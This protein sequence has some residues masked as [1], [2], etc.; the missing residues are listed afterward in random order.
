MR[1]NVLFY[2]SGGGLRALQCHAGIIQACDKFGVKADRKTGV[3]GGAIVAAF[4]SMG[5]SGVDIEAELRKLHVD[6]L[7]T[8]NWTYPLFA[9]SL[10]DNSGMREV[11][12]SFIGDRVFGDVTCVVTDDESNE[13]RYMPASVRT[14]MASSAIPGVF[15]PELIDGRLYRDG[16]IKNNIPTPK[17]VDRTKYGKIFI[18]VCNEDDSIVQ[19][20]TTKLGKTLQWLDL[21]TTR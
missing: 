1:E 18:F 14:L 21:T 19:K 16:G 12:R 10:Y 3:S 2:L 17:G 4:N 5:M 20:Q 15:P 8:R 11:I 13:V 9:D 6:D 7:F